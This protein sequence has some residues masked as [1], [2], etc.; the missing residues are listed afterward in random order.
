MT[1]MTPDGAPLRVM[2]LNPVGTD[3]Y[4]A[5][6]ADAIGAIRLP[7]T[8]VHVTSLSPACG[9]FTHIEFRS[10]EA[11]VT[12]GIVRAARAAGREG[13]DALAIG[14]FYDTAL[15]DARELS[16]EMV[17]T[18]PCVAAME[19]AASL[20]NRFGIIVGRRKWVDQMHAT[21]VANGMADRLSGFY[22][23]GLGVNDFQTDHERTNALLVEAGRKAV[24]DDHA[25]AIILGCTLEIGFHETLSDILGVP[26]IDPALAAFRR[27]EYGAILKRLSGWIPSRK[28]SCEAPSE[29]EMALFGGFDDPDVF[30][31]RIVL[32]AG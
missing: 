20:S 12:P 8:E 15:H 1:T 9:R 31:N 11:M 22:T 30:G 24:E 32:G 16:G 23:V 28:W 4:D 18:A 10:Y 2:Y 13:F 5:V 21:V 26:V 25:E 3:G 14:C 6:F 19:I 17:V 29:E 27:A 7:G